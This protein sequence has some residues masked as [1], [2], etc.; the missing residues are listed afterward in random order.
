MNRGFL[1]PTRP[2]RAR[3]GHA[4]LLRRLCAGLAALAITMLGACGGALDS[5]PDTE[6]A[7]YIPANADFAAGTRGPTN[8]RPSRHGVEMLRSLLQGSVA[9][10]WEHAL[11]GRWL[12]EAFPPRPL[13]P[14][15]E[16][17]DI[18]PQVR[19]FVAYRAGGQDVLRLRLATATPIVRWLHQLHGLPL[20]DE[21]GIS[22]WRIE[23]GGTPWQVQQVGNQLTVFSVVDAH[24]DTRGQAVAQSRSNS[25]AL[26]LPT[27]AG[28]F[29]H[30]VAET[31]PMPAPFTPSANGCQTL[32][33]A[34]HDI[35]EHLTLDVFT[36]PRG[37]TQG[38]WRASLI[39]SQAAALMQEI[40]PAPQLNGTPDAQIHA[41]LGLGSGTLEENFAKPA[42][43]L[44]ISRC[45]LQIA[46]QRLDLTPGLLSPMPAWLNGLHSIAVNVLPP[47][48]RQGWPGV[49]AYFG[50]DQ[51]TAARQ[52]LALAY[53][54]P[55][56]PGANS[57]TAQP[58]SLAVADA[59]GALM[60]GFHAPLPSLSAESPARTDRAIEWAT[61]HVPGKVWEQ[62]LDT[63]P[64]RDPV[65]DMPSWVDWLSSSQDFQASLSLSGKDLV[66]HWSLRER[67]LV[68]SKR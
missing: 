55:A 10:P 44:P 43:V 40:A 23:T 27:S 62:L 67:R 6:L 18:V 37:T 41:S 1:E 49:Q 52:T 29:L 31:D 30:L 15:F 59:A 51:P 47:A 57:A 32:W 60:L 42:Q 13:F 61:L 45:L 68:L 7:T 8:R 34:F 16:G 9:P 3:I 54:P 38:R 2:R 11:P 33:R 20:R 4:Q 24:S 58:H 63:G 21:S 64:D 12:S 35:T 39:A 48:T 46:R 14:V 36:D 53:P 22:I 19:G 65:A 25:P 50:L 28:E 17:I 56:K 26:W 66:L 5:D